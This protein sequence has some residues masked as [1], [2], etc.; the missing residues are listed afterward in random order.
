[1]RRLKYFA[2]A[3][4]LLVL[5]ALACA[6][7]LLRA[8]LPQLDGEL[9]ERGVTAS[10]RITRDARGVPTIEAADRLDLAYA[11]GFVHAQDRYFQMDLARRLAAGE[12]A[13]LFGRVA[14]EEDLKTRLFRF[15]DVARRVVEAATPVQRAV[16]EAYSRGVNAGLGALGARPWEYG[17]L[18]QR[19]APWRA[20]DS[21]LVI[22]SMW[23]DLQANGFRREILRQ[24]ID[25]AL[26]GPV[27]ADGF[28]CALGFF[29]PHGTEWDAPVQPD[30][31]P[32][33]RVGI[34]DAAVLDVRDASS[35]APPSAAFLPREKGDA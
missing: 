14:L 5:A 16:L 7:A 18:G 4:G 33:A 31:E 19:P 3:A 22:Y 26:G 24:Q 28:K 10:V 25:A 12:L 1:M 6:Y 35:R 2:A 27:C 17:L 13:E 9:R 11:T 21:V 32:L 30:S 20:E 15:R 23:W 8:S 34:P 29:Y